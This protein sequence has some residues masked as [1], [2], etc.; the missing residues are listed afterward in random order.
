MKS[1]LSI[2]SKIKATIQVTFLLLVISFDSSVA[3]GSLNE[4]VNQ[5][6]TDLPEYKVNI[7]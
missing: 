4:K 5:R 3:Q 7:S 2:K 1:S 6:S